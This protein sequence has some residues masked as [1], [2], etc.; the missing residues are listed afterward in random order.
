MD[1]FNGI[2]NKCIFFPEE[3][4]DIELAMMYGENPVLQIT[5]Q[6][7][8]NWMQWWARKTI[9]AIT[10]GDIEEARALIVGTQQVFNSLFVVINRFPPLKGSKLTDAY[11]LYK[12]IR[13]NR[14]PLEKTRN[15]MQALQ[16]IYGD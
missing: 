4:T 11:A 5:P 9:A 13:A 2:I 12:W 16:Q 14:D 7:Y 1:F 3:L 15:L 10:R 8:I 6:W